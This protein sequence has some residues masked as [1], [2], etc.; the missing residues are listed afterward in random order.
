VPRSQIALEN[1][2]EARRIVAGL[3]TMVDNKSHEDNFILTVY[4]II[5]VVEC[6]ATF[7][8]KCSTVGSLRRLPR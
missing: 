3:Q 7:G 4:K 2:K 6:S 5:R 1:L 8:P